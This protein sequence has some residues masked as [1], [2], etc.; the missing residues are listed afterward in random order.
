MYIQTISCI[1][2]CRQWEGCARLLGL[3]PRAEAGSAASAQASTLVK[4]FPFPIRG[5]R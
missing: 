1:L 3:A 4:L 5:C 2:Y